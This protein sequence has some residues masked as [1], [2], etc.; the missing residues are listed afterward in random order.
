M[1]RAYGRAAN[2]DSWARRSLAA[3]TILRAFVICCVF[4]TL[5]IRLR[6]SMSAGMLYPLIP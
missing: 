4:L 1:V 2:M 6:M 5:R 3:E